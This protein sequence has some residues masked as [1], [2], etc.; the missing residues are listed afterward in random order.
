[1][2]AAEGDGRMVSFSCGADAM[3]ET[4]RSL[5][6]PLDI[7]AENDR[8]SCVVGGPSTALDTLTT[9]CFA[10]GIQAQALRVAFAFHTRYMAPAA[11]DL[12]GLLSDLPMVE[13]QL[14]LYSTVTGERHAAAALDGAHWAAGVCQP[15]RFADAMAAAISDDFSTF[16]CVSPQSV[17]HDNMAA[18]ARAQGR[19][20]S[21]FPTLRR[22]FEARRSLLELLGQCHAHGLLS[23]LHALHPEADHLDLPLT[24]WDRRRCWPDMTNRRE[25]HVLTGLVTATTASSAVSSDTPAPV[26]IAS[27]DQALRK[28][29][30]AERVERLQD[31]LMDEVAALIGAEVSTLS[32]ELP[33]MTMGFDSHMGLGLQVRLQGML[34]LELPATLIWSYVDVRRLAVHLGQ[35]LESGPDVLNP[36]GP[37]TLASPLVSAD[38]VDAKPL[39]SLSQL[40]DELEAS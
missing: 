22:R 21:S 4:I 15:V 25:G 35:L 32:P 24:P 16:V 14:P 28:L 27:L 33:F 7:A 8:Q 10:Q 39:D 12:A 1:M 13:P 37:T 6:L 23:G 31:H 2:Q 38:V 26:A 40:L 9:H 30:R 29:N 19:T 3:R 34:N 36:T 18:V 20:V 17:L 5:D 11:A